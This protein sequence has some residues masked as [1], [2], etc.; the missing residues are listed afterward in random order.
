[1]EWEALAIEWEGLA[2]VGGLAHLQYRRRPDSGL[3]F[4][5]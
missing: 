3:G 4:A 5:L 2:V 1:M